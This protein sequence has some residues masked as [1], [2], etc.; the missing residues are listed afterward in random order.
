MQQSFCFQDPANSICVENIVKNC[1]AHGIIN[2][3]D[4]FEKV[5]IAGGGKS[6]AYIFG[7]RDIHGKFG[8]E[9]GKRM[10]LKYY[11]TSFEAIGAVNEERPFRE[12]ITL[13]RLSGITG[14][15]CL[16]FYGCMQTPSAWFASHKDEPPT[17]HGL[18]ALMSEAA[19]VSL[20]DL[21][22]NALSLEDIRGIALKLLIIMEHGR[23]R[24]GPDF[25]HFDLHADN[26]FV[27][28]D[29]CSNDVVQLQLQNAD[30]RY[31]MR[32]FFY[33]AK[34]CPA[35]TIIDFDLVRGSAVL[36]HAN[37]NYP[38]FNKILD[39]HKSKY[40]GPTPVPERTIEFMNRMIGVQ[41]TMALM[42]IIS[43]HDTG[44]DMANWF[45]LV[46]TML[47]HHE[48]RT[49]E[50]ANLPSMTF[51]RTARMCMVKNVTMFPDAAQLVIRN[52]SNTQEGTDLMNSYVDA[53]RLDRI[54][55]RHGQQIHGFLKL[56]TNAA[57]SSE[58][59][60]QIN[61][62]SR[63][64]WDQTNNFPTPNDTQFILTVGSPGDVRY[65]RLQNAADLR[66]GTVSVHVGTNALIPY[67]DIRFP[68]YKTEI[69]TSMYTLFNFWV[70]MKQGAFFLHR[71]AEKTYTQSI[72][73]TLGIWAA[74]LSAGPAFFA[75][76][77]LYA[78]IAAALLAWAGSGQT[79]LV[80]LYSIHVD[81]GPPMQISIYIDLNNTLALGI[82]SALHNAGMVRVGDWMEMGTSRLRIDH[83]V[84]IPAHYGVSE[85]VFVQSEIVPTV[86]FEEM[87]EEPERKEEEMIET[88][89]I[90]YR[91]GEGP[92]H[93][94]IRFLKAVLENKDSSPAYDVCRK[95]LCE[96]ILS[97]LDL[98]QAVY[99]RQCGML[100]PRD[101]VESKTSLEPFFDSPLELS[102]FHLPTNIKQHIDFG[103]DAIPQI[104]GVKFPRDM[105]ILDYMKLF[106]TY[107]RLL[108]IPPRDPAAVVV[109][110]FVLGDHETKE[111]Q[112]IGVSQVTRMAHGVLPSDPP[113][114]TLPQA[115]WWWSPE[116]EERKHE[117][118]PAPPAPAPAPA[119]PPARA[120]FFGGIRGED[121][122]RGRADFAL[123][124]RRRARAN[125]FRNLRAVGDADVDMGDLPPLPQ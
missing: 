66:L 61:T 70:Q 25:Q 35:V 82:E 94:C 117:A 75:I 3:V 92:P 34:A 99:S 16:F 47:R 110:P 106:A 103:H 64:V 56:F 29:N 20:L 81:V 65:Y 96:D 9:K 41:E 40:T 24:M 71:I 63:K 36:D 101:H 7:V 52:F 112:H 30:P 37:P 90:I 59:G 62:F 14:F 97:S 18:F 33:T 11:S 53:G 89:R 19:G 100:K 72:P 50:P 85:K 123:A 5:F 125:I 86:M 76:F 91:L 1:E 23:R 93:A 78:G 4:F 122:R 22:V 12:V 55:I 46:Y 111:T 28:M 15:P 118:P 98:E 49:R 84:K 32:N 120:R 107:Y 80:K 113:D 74:Q 44:Q 114:T 31:D 57:I 13:C 2:P 10:I 42:G 58:M 68:D 79:V 51:C 8:G 88:D 45:V 38:R 54:R 109:A 104:P 26:I 119:P 121:R 6:G 67:I 48:L 108:G 105:G 69:N 102:A 116:V 95:A 17:G 83:G 60:K 43:Q 124:A 73:K 77:G 27:D 87:M 115:G 39:E 21:D